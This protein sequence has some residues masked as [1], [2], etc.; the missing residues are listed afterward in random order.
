MPRKPSAPTLQ[1]SP[2]WCL[3]EWLRYLGVRQ[4]DLSRR[5]G[6]SKATTSDIVNGRTSY[7]RQIVNEAAKALN[8]AAHELLMT[9]DEAMAM[10]RLRQS[11]MTIVEAST[12]AP[13]VPFKRDGTRG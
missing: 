10:R 1:P 13:V 4:A 9:P 8:L 11:A 3:V 7:Y 2:D 6:W 12:P 5:T